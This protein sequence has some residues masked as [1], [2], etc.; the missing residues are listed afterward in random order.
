MTVSIADIKTR[1]EML[2]GDISGVKLVLKEDS[3]Q[4]TLL[5]AAEVLVRDGTRQTLD[6]GRVRVTRNFEIF[7][8]IEKLAQ[9]ENDAVFIDALENSLSWIDTVADFFMQRPRLERE[10]S[11]IVYGTGDIRDSAALPV[12]YRGQA[13]AAIRWVLPVIIHRESV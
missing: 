1:I 9:L 13:Y 2:L 5:P 6:S 11:G 12:T 7:L 3:R 10:D 8:Y 4:I